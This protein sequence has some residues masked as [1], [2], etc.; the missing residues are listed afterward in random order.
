MQ[1]VRPY[2]NILNQN[3]QLARPSKDTTY[4]SLRSPF[5]PSLNSSL[6]ELYT[7][8]Y[9]NHSC[10]SLIFES[11]HFFFAMLKNNILAFYLAHNL[12]HFS[13]SPSL[14]YNAIFKIKYVEKCTFLCLWL[15]TQE[16]SHF[17][18][19]LENWS[20]FS[21]LRVLLDES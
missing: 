13:S 1:N 5:S 21:G 20:F 15:L 9:N 6:T 2:P 18:L 14:L 19:Y 7:C 10:W 17:F 16:P 3:P 11:S 8:W 12:L 4:Q